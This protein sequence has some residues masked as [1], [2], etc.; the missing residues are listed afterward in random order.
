MAG[1]CSVCTR[2][3]RKAIDAALAFSSVRDIAGRFGLSKTAVHAHKSR[4]LTPAV[5]RAIAT[6]G[7]LSAAALVQ[8]LAELLETCDDAMATAKAATDLKALTSLIRESRELVVTIGRTIGLWTDH[9]PSVL[10]DARR[11]TL[12]LAVGELSDAQLR[13]AVQRAAALEPTIEANHAALSRGAS[14]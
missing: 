9:R 2:E 7:D 3:D 5:A 13:A 4:H 1:R 8:R 14:A 11:Q 10:V 12:N 6:R